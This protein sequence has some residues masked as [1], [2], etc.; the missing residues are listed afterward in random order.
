MLKARNVFMLQRRWKGGKKRWN[1]LQFKKTNCDRALES[2]DDFYGSVYGTR[3]KNMRVA[4]LTE[5]KY[6]AMVNNF[7]DTEQTCS[8]LEMDGAINVK[9]LI[10]VARER[11]DGKTDNSVSTKL[12]SSNNVDSKLDALL[13]KQQEREM[14]SIYPSASEDGMPQQLNYNSSEKNQSTQEELEPQ[15]F[16]QSLTKALEEDVHLDEK[17]LVDPQF[18]TGGLYEYMPAHSIK[19]MEDWVAESEHYKYYKTNDAFPLRIE[20]EDSFQFPEHLALY[21]YE[22]GNCSNFKAPKKCLT[23][24]LSHFLMD[25]ASTL[26]PLFLQIQPGDRVLDAC[27]APGG[28]AR[29]QAA[30]RH[31]RVPVRL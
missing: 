16:K 1:A 6:I 22:M 27:A 17:R 9:S 3:W 26:P 19:G 18:G 20:L 29:E 14:A 30:A 24:V 31:A 15:D 12:P 23:G 28:I 7:G 2:F 5:H 8:M 11:L 13:K 4:L 25:G 10:N 21:T